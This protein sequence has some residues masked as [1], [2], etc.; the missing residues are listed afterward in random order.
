MP[1]PPTQ[2]A[3]EVTYRDE[4]LDLC[5]EVSPEGMARLTRLAARSDQGDQGE[6]R[7]GG[8]ASPASGQVGSPR[9]PSG[10]PL[11]DVVTPGS[12][13][14]WSGHRYVESETGA[15]MR[16]A[17]GS[18][19]TEGRWRVLT[20]LLEDPRSGLRAEVVYRVLQGAGVLRSTTRLLNDGPSPL[21]VESV[22]SFLGSGLAGPGG[23][24]GDLEIF[25]AENDWLSE[26]RWQRRAFRDA[27][28]DLDRRVHGADPRAMFGFTSQ[29]GWSSAGY[30]PM[31][32]AV[33]RRTGHAWLW[34]V[35]HNGGW[36]WQVGE[37]TG[38]G[39]EQPG[40]IGPRSSPETA[41]YLALLGPTDRE[42]HW[43]LVL[44][45]GET[46]ETVP[47]AVAL[48][49]EGFEGA[50][51]RMTEYRRAARRPHLDHVRL[52]VI[53]ND[54]MNTV[55]GEP[56]TARLLPLVDA[57]ANTG[58][59][60]FCIDSGWYAE[61]GERWWET[62]GD[63]RPSSSRFPNGIEEVLD[64][65]RARG[66]VP[67]L[68]LEPEVVGTRS[69]AA[70][71]LPDEAFFCRRGERVVEQG[72]Y[73]LDLRHPAARAHLDDAVDLL[74]GDLG[75]GYL[76][77]DYNVCPTPGTDTGGLSEGAGLLGHNRALLEWLDGLLERHPG[78][79]IENCASGGMRADFAMLSRLQLQSTSD[80][81]D[82]LRYAAI[83]AAAPA[84]MTPEQAASW[85]YPQPEWSDDEITFTLCGA[86][87]GR[88]HLS[89]NLDRMSGHQQRLVAEALEVYKR[90]RS[91]LP[92]SV[93]F[94]PLGLPGWT[95]TWL[96]L[97][98]R[99][100]AASYVL[101]WHRPA[102][103]DARRP[104]AAAERSSVILPV[105]HLRGRQARGELVYPVRGL[106][107]IFWDEAL[108]QLKVEL[109]RTPS[110]CLVELRAG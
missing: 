62:V 102:L 72:R 9:S 87:L 17:G 98:L 21:A 37:H 71:K 105:P 100:L 39:D 79:T 26:N 51:A 86:M 70:G 35:E 93:P 50:L 88:F 54:Y 66:M 48:S 82:F 8:R 13:R 55:M 36:H 45:P 101:V 97:G 81:Q 14:A 22:T 84:A 18:Q 106:A 67:G 90:V 25:W 53:F 15:R 75:I 31:G 94:W 92:R 16:Y 107:T 61:L 95:D 57:A 103:D 12:G 4:V 11:L 89:G 6:S 68:W 74:V 109:P 29:G 5:V 110:A 2:P 23:E 64:A 20:F 3:G 96:A 30:L 76:K 44:E 78:L 58:A 60:C 85:A 46:F 19:R 38:R 7:V 49:G 27:L 47:G 42:H 91:E 65:I 34:Q 69:V 83:S 77:I 43:Y 10:L 24:L 40:A 80:Q 104:G 33:N 41:A 32:A 56:T 28:P 63:W 99:N 52:P 108:G 1:A 59:E 73:L